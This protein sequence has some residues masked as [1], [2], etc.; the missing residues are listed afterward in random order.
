MKIRKFLSL[1]LALV[2]AMSLA[3]PAFADDPAGGEEEEEE[4]ANDTFTAPAAVMI[5]TIAVTVP[6]TG[7]VFVNP[8]GF[9]VVTASGVA[10]TA[11]QAG[12]NSTTPTSSEKIVSPVYC[13]VNNSPMT[14][15]VGVIASATINTGSTMTLSAVP[16]TAGSTKKEA[17]VYARFAPIESDAYN[18]SVASGATADAALKIPKIDDDDEPG[19]TLVAK[20]IN[21]TPAVTEADALAA[22]AAAGAVAITTKAPTTP[23]V[24]GQLEEGSDAEP[25][26]LGFQFYGDA[27]TTPKEAWD[28]AVDGVQVSMVFSFNP[29]VED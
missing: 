7:Q 4:A 14:L 10:A 3:I 15:D 11:E 2:M 22:N 21:D 13:I 1:I 19:W 12:D 23:I 25:S 5:P 6:S 24:V 16:L 28:T 8:F 18:D 27:V 17:F 29:A 26:Y 20:A 9:T